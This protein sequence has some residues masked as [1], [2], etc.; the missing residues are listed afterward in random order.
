MDKA[1]YNPRN[2]WEKG[3]EW[4]KTLRASGSCR[5]LE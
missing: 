4:W 1:V 3:C 2:R 5:T